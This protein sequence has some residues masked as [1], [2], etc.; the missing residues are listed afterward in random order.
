MNF[1]LCSVCE[2]TWMDTSD[3]LD[4]RGHGKRMY[5]QISLDMDGHEGLGGRTWT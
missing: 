3:F 2:W 5:I 1:H 4:G